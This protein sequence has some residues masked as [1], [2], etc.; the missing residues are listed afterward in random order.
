MRRLVL[1][2][3]RRVALHEL[4]D[5]PDGRT[6]VFCHSAP[7]SGAF[8]PDPEQTAGRGIRLIGLDRAGYGGSEPVAAGE[9]AT[10]ARA[11]D[12]VAEVLGQLGIDRAGVAGWSAGGRVALA[13]AARYPELVDRVVVFG[14]PAPD[15]HVPWIAPEQK[16]MLEAL[17]GHTPD[18]VHARLAA[19]FAPMLPADPRSEAALQLLGAGE[20][21]AAA[22]ASP[23]AG[24]RL[25]AM[26]AAAFAQG[27]T[28][29]AADVAGYCL[30]PWG[31]EPSEVRAK[32]LVLYGYRDP[33][34][35]I[36]HGSWWQKN[37][38]DARLEMVPDAG[39]LL[40]IPMWRRALSHL[41]PRRKAPG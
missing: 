26:V 33:V 27:A 30:Q 41:S 24:D 32:T 11:A 5:G 15:E 1:R 8:D 35:T 10:V 13:F 18:E 2:S 21:D 3:G 14:T 9:W 6:I 29:M 36:R 34:A 37:L 4:A 19:A 28:G 12:D 22:L 20:A 31:F 25:G 40:V 38:P 23:G 16:Q 17:R 7:G 39:H